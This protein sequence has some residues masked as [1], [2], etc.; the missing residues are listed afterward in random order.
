MSRL[1]KFIEQ[2]VTGEKS[3]RA[4]YAFGPEKLPPPGENLEW[5][6][7]SSFNAAAEIMRDAGLK[8]IFILAIDEGCAIVEDRTDVAA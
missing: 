7:V 1:Q 2:S 3:K 6:T 8:N 4:A 5:K